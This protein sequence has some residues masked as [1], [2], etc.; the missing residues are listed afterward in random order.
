MTPEVKTARERLSTALKA[1]V[2]A[3]EKVP[4]GAWN[5]GPETGAGHVWLYRDGAPLAEP[6]HWLRRAF[7]T[8]CDHEPEWM[9]GETSDARMD[10]FW[11]AKQDAA[12]AIVE[13]G[14][15][16]A[17]HGPAMLGILAALDE[18]EAQRDEWKLKAVTLTPDSPSERL[19]RERDAAEARA[20]V[21]AAECRAWR[22]AYYN[23]DC[24]GE[25]GHCRYEGASETTVAATDAAGALEGK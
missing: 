6:M 4:G 8:R 3:R 14:N 7:K 22:A 16:I 23:N 12:A 9:P 18:A 11:K 24:D 5:T 10:R 1:T 25:S 17:E 21:L 2:A 15:F 19:V 13:C 20:E